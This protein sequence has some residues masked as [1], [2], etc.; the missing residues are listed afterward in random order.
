MMSKITDTSLDE[1]KLKVKRRLNNYLAEMADNYELF[2]KETFDLQYAGARFIQNGVEGE[3]AEFVKQ[4]YEIS[5]DGRTLEEFAQSIVDKH[6]EREQ[7][8]RYLVLERHRL[9]NIV[10]KATTHDEIIRLL[11]SLGINPEL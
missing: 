6:D 11:K 8:V 2:E 10:E 4:L 7:Y 1:Y 3:A 9:H 5:A